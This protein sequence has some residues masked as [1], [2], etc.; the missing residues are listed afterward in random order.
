MN[1]FSKLLVIGALLS[2]AVPALAD[3]ERKGVVVV[4]IQRAQLDNEPQ[5]KING[6]AVKKGYELEQVRKACAKNMVVLMGPDAMFRDLLNFGFVSSKNGF[7]ELNKNYFLFAYA[8]GKKR[9]TYLKNGAETD[10]SDDPSMLDQLINHPPEYSSFH[11]SAL[12]S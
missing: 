8:P 5:I 10:F 3:C 12:G 9:M 2:P 1:A 7:H 4:D 11:G 6:I